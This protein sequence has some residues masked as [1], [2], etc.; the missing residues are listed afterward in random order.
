ML[1]E[2]EVLE[3]ITLDLLAKGYGI[4]DKAMVH[5]GDVDIVARQLKTGAK[6]F[7]TAA[8]IARST[9]GRGKLEQQ[10]TERQLFH[11]VARSINGAF[12]TGDRERFNPG[13]K[14]AL[15]FPDI[16]GYK[17]YLTVQ[18]PI[19]DSLG[20]IVFLVSEDGAVRTL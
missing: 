3:A 4:L 14:I 6:L 12:K 11:S 15:A 20:I 10:F 8:G 9:A 1:D 2:K 7:I 13:D 19:L 17:K 5:H 18:K 16:P